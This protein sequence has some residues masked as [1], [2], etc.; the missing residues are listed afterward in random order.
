MNHALS[1]RTLIVA[2]GAMV[3]IGPFAIDTY[4]PGVPAMAQD[5]G[6]RTSDVE[7]SISLYLLGAAVGQLFAGPLSD[8]FGR[9]RIAYIGLGLFVVTSAIIAL[10][11]SVLALDVLRVVQAMGGGVTV[12]TTGATVRDH[13]QGRAAARM[14]TAIGMVM[15]IA[16]LIAPAVG[17]G[18]ITLG[19]WRLIFVCLAL[20]GLV[21]IVVVRKVLPEPVPSALPPSRDGLVTR[22]R[23]VL[24]FAPGRFLIVANG[25]SF[26]AIFAFIT[27]SAFLYLEF[28]R[29]GDNLFPVYF[30]ANVVAMLFFNRLN[31]VLLRHYEAPAIMAVGV[32]ALWLSA[33][34][35]LGQFLLWPRPSLWTVVPNIMLLG[36][37]VA[38]VMPNGIAS[39]LQLFP[40]DAGTAS[41][42]NGSGQFLVSGVLGVTLV[43]FHDG[44]PVPMAVA[45]V[46]AASL[47]AY[48]RYRAGRDHDL[49]QVA[50]G[51]ALPDDVLEQR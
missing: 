19:G 39:L 20:Y 15:L 9:K 51:Q 22:W 12:I 41:G 48:G 4:I 32:V 18:L 25:F 8:R 49:T 46:V 2:L 17:R 40:R 1:V 10:V 29:V 43:S 42:L 33:L 47:A 30:G 28:Y 5:F 21:L 3:A 31:V 24:A 11:D 36:G 16:P 14:I 38:L 7:R 37:L 6:V 35:L 23:R 26:A 34:L 44:T 45:M 50:P 13:F 27:D